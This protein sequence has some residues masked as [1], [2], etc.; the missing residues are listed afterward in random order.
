MDT[1]ESIA[2]QFYPLALEHIPIVLH[3]ECEA[4]PEPWNYNMLR[5]ELDN[6]NAFFCV[7][8]LGDE[9]AGYG[10]YWYMVDEAHITRVTV[11]PPL[12][13]RGYSRRLMLHIMAHAEKRAVEAIRLEVRE[14]N[15]PAIRLY[16][17]LGFSHAGRRM[18]YY[19]STNENALVMVKVAGPMSSPPPS[20]ETQPQA[21]AL[22]HE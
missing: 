9:F 19:Q 21:P 3:A 2:L 4:Y 18:G 12:R 1:H 10:G 6:P 11:V 5:Q 7:M 22:P 16:E 20:H 17:S 15:Y 8:Y 14:H 13:G